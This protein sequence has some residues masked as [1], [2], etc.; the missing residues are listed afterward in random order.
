[1]LKLLNLKHFSPLTVI[2]KYYV[3]LWL[4][5]II[6]YDWIIFIWRALKSS[7]WTNILC[8]LC[9]WIQV[10]ELRTKFPNHPEFR[11]LQILQTDWLLVMSFL[12]T[13]VYRA[14]HQGASIHSSSDDAEEVR[15]S[16]FQLIHLRHSTGEVLKPLRRAASGKSLVAAV[17]PVTFITTNALHNQ[18]RSWSE[19]YPWKRVTEAFLLCISL[20]HQGAPELC[21]LGWVDEK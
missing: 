19:V 10:V 5:H 7:K 8:L 11:L 3:I 14:A 1:M 4:Y 20:L 2:H 6:L 16:F 15:W 21:S 9:I 17:Q 13:N 18:T 12:S